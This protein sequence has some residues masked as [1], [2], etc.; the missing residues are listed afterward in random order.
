MNVSLKDL[1]PKALDKFYFNLLSSSVSL[2]GNSYNSFYD[3]DYCF[4]L[5]SGFSSN[6]LSYS[7]LLLNIDNWDNLV[8]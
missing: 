4:S 6:L 5:T 3:N 1:L 7:S 8:L 2:T